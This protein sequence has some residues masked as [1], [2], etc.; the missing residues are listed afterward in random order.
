MGG[1]GHNHS[2]GHSH[3]HSHSH[4][5]KVAES[6]HGRANTGQ[7][8]CM[9]SCKGQQRNS[10]SHNH[11]RRHSRSHRVPTASPPSRSSTQCTLLRGHHVRGPRKI[12]H[13]RRL[14]RVHQQ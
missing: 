14:L 3:R 2:H 4:R 10:H 11:S 1:H 7:K 12:K 8:N 9:C 5:G 13:A 6:Q